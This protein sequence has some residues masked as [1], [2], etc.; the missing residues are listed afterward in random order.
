MV[1]DDSP[2]ASESTNLPPSASIKHLRWPVTAL[3]LGGL[4]LITLGQ[5]TYPQVYSGLRWRVYGLMGFGLIA[6]FTGVHTASGTAVAR[7]ARPA[8][9]PVLPN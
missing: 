8:V 3:L 5:I 7:Q 9:V 4:I 1:A 6:F 2:C